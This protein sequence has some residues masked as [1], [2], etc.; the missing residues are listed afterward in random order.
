MTDEI[1]SRTTPSLFDLM[2]ALASGAA[3]A[4]AV[5]SPRVGA[6][7][8]GVA[9]ATALV[10][11][12]AAAGILLAR[13][14]FAWSGGALLIMLTNVVAIELAFATVFWMSGYRRMTTF[15]EGNFWLFVRR[16][17]LSLCIVAV[18]AVVLGMQF[19]QAVSRALFENEVRDVLRTHF[20]PKAG[21]YLADTRFTKE[22]RALVITAVLRGPKAPSTA[23]VAAAQ[24]SLP[25]FWEGLKADLHVRF[26]QVL[27]V[28]P[29]GDSFDGLDAEGGGD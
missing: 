13:G 14:D 16:N 22:H 10:P 7:I 6:A 1:I 19:K 17:V 9:V 11:P 29:E 4:V 24:A 3:G 5:V 8:V 12:L 18:L 27:I 20:T 2:I 15:G 23:D 25:A 26:V 28:T 21:F